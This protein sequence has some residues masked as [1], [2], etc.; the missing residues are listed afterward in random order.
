MEQDAQQVIQKS[1]LPIK[2]KIAA[3]WMSIIGGV[4]LLEFY[5]VWFE[6][7]LFPP[8]FRYEVAGEVLGL[9]LLG[10]LFFLPGFFL[11][12]TRKKWAWWLA[13]IIISIFLI[14]IPYFIIGDLLLAGYHPDLDDLTP[15]PF[16]LIP[17]ILLLL[18]RKNFWKIAT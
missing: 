7:P 5:R 12:I 17:F 8:L 10:S 13:I 16:L 6:I 3:W 11:L 1:S 4:L 2:T 14:F 15:L 18:D 9:S